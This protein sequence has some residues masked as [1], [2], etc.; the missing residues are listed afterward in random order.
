M[1]TPQLLTDI[2]NVMMLL[3][4]RPRSYAWCW[5]GSACGMKPVG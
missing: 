3:V 5:P 2:A 4:P 1:Q